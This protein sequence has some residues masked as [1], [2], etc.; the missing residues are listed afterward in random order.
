MWRA[1]GR[2]GR[3]CFTGGF[4]LATALEPSVVASVMSQPAMPARIGERCR[5]ALG[6]EAE[7]L[8]TITTSGE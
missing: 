2:R 8:S 5:A 1:R 4:A 6:L 7:D 3:M